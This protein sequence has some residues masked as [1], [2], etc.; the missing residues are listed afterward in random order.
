MTEQ[1]KNDELGRLSAFH[2]EADRSR[3]GLNIVLSGI[4]GI[5]EFSDEMICLKGH[6]GRI[7]VKGKHLFINVYENANVEIV[8]RVEEVVFRYGKN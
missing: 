6:G 5:S 3:S 1:N 2:L 8:G 7:Y 4:V